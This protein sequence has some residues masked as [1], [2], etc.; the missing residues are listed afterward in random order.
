MALIPC[1]ECK[2]LISEFSLHCVTCGCPK[3]KFNQIQKT[4]YCAS[5]IKNFLENSDYSELEKHSYDQSFDDT[6]KRLRETSN[7]NLLQV[8]QKEIVKRVLSENHYNQVRSAKLLGIT[9]AT[10]RKK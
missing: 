6:Y 1:P 4:H 10:L 2:K 3:E 9:R 8:V 5:S 7:E